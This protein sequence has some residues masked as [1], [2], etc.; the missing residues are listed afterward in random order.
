MGGV[1]IMG[2]VL[3]SL[4][5]HIRLSIKE[6]EHEEAQERMCD[7]GLFFRICHLYWCLIHRHAG[8]SR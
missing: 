8:L 1:E 7:A 2:F 3:G 6:E 5:A 4:R